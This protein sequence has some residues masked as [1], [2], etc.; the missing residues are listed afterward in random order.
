MNV[1]YIARRKEVDAEGNKWVRKSG[2]KFLETCS[3]DG[4]SKH[5][6]VVGRMRKIKGSAGSTLCICYVATIKNSSGWV[7]PNDKEVE[8]PGFK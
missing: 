4:G 2:T 8:S 7:L 5:R 1:G 6:G 3:A